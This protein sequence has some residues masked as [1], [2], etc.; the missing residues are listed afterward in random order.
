MLIS[1][2]DSTYRSYGRESTR[3]INS[4]LVFCWVKLSA[5]CCTQGKSVCSVIISLKSGPWK[6]LR[7]CD[8]RYSCLSL[9]NFFPVPIFVAMR[10]DFGVHR[11]P[12]K[13][14]DQMT[15]PSLWAVW[16]CLNARD[17]QQTKLFSKYIFTSF[18]RCDACGALWFGPDGKMMFCVDAL[19]S[20]LRKSF[21][22]ILVFPN[23]IQKLSNS[24]I[25][26]SMFGGYGSI[27]T[28]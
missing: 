26:S 14:N 25:P 7:R 24:T 20:F 9:R 19:C 11:S 28:A 23:L 6:A 5:L 3:S 17:P 18:Y 15:S 8:A 1:S 2:R 21:S 12:G 16:K 13:Y 4:C 22:A 10:A 27:L